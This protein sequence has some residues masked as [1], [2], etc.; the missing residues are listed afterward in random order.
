MR[1]GACALFMAVVLCGLFCFVVFAQEFSADIV[2]TGKEGS[3]SGKIYT[4]KNKIR[5]EQQGNIIISRIDR[6]VTWII[7][8]AEK[9]YIEQKVD[10]RNIA[11]VMDEV[12]GQ[13]ERQALGEE[14]IDGRMTDK[15]KV[16]YTYGG[17]TSGMFVWTTQGSNI[18]VKTMAVDGSW[19]MEYKNLREGPQ[20]DDLFE[21]PAGYEKMSLDMSQMG[22][23]MQGSSY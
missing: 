4:S 21:I 12:P 3:S 22:N 1:G 16:D 9:V 8:P 14:E 19:S 15:Y 10:P 7:M 18:P 17:E 6:N 2:S 23:M 13:V 11:G 5:M 20:S